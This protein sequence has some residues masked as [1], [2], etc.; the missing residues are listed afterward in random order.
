MCYTMVGK[1]SEIM[2][3]NRGLGI[4][5]AVLAVMVLGLGGYLVYDKVI[6]KAPEVEKPAETPAETT[7]KATISEMIK[8]VSDKYSS[9]SDKELGIL[10]TD[11][12]YIYLKLYEYY[13]AGSP[14]ITLVIVNDNLEEIFKEVISEAGQ[15]LRLEQ[16]DSSYELYGYQNYYITTDAIYYLSNDYSCTNTTAKE[17]KITVS[18]NN[19]AKTQIATHTVIGS[20]SCS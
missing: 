4:L 17:Y 16:N 15:Y 19:V 2:D 12:G 1:G 11:K 20:G 13:P 10:V 8:K 6:N 5:V 18:N 9:V 14:K 3:K 7:N